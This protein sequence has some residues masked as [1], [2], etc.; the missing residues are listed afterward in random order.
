MKMGVSFTP[1]L[2][3]LCI[4]L[5]WS[6]VNGDVLSWSFPAVEKNLET[7]I[8]QRSGLIEAIAQA[9]NTPTPSPT[10]SP[11]VAASLAD[12]PYRFSRYGNQWIH[13]LSTPLDSTM[14]KSKKVIA[15]SIA[16]IS[17]SYN[18][19]KYNDLAKIFLKAY[20]ESELSPIPIMESYL[21]ILTTNKYNGSFGSFDDGAYDA[22][23]AMIAPVKFLI[24]LFGADSINIWIAMLLKKRVI[25]YHPRL[26][27]VQ[28]LVKVRWELEGYMRHENL[29]SSLIIHRRADISKIVNRCRLFVTC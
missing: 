22:R 29:V 19:Q 20:T 4:F 14:A 12:A 21:S 11:I 28:N 10:L 17:S 27:E 9:S 24:Q 3:V 26:S 15:C 7:V 16:I 13:I 25:I 18:P 2:S 1:P 23:R 8:K 5:L 6:D